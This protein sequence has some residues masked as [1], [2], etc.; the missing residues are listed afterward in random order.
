MPAL[1][2]REY[3]PRLRVANAAEIFARWK[4]RAE[5]V[6]AARRDTLELRYGPA[7]AERLDFF[8]APHA[9][10]PLLIFVHGGY[11]RAFDKA[12]F[13]WVAPAYVEAGAAV[14]VVNYGLAP[15]TPIEEIVRQVERA[16]AWLHRHA[17]ELRIDRDR[18]VCAGHSAGGHLAAMMLTT[19]WPQLGT[20]LPA[21]LIAGAVAVSGLYDLR[22]LVDAEFLKD[23][24]RLDRE[25]AQHL[26]PAF[27]QPACQSPIVVAVGALESGEFHRQ[28]QLLREAWGGACVRDT[29]DVPDTDHFSVCEAF[30]TSGNALFDATSRLLDVG[31]PGSS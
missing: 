15:A 11:W 2:T 24:L 19:V 12:D 31:A 4:L 9:A 23:D 5:E 16:C 13:S 1:S 28:G 10:A 27:R 26:S 3:N 6:R 25:R 7:P 21:Q 8:P 14:A 22:P 30:A 18:I 29:L 17:N 20:G